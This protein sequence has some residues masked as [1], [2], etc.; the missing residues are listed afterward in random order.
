MVEA[1]TEKDISDIEA[2]KAQFNDK[3]ELFDFS[4]LDMLD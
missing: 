3:R 2:I 4:H 1:L